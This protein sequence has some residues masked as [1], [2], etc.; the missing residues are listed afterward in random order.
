[1]VVVMVVVVRVLTVIPNVGNTVDGI[2][3][4]QAWRQWARRA[5]GCKM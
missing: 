4:A 3:P 5:I 2:Y 1:M